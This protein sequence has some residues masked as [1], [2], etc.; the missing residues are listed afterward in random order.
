MTS[1]T[2]K[3]HCREERRKGKKIVFGNGCFDLLHVG[4]VRYLQAAKALGDILI[5]GVND[6]ASLVSL[7]KRSERDHALGGADRDPRGPGVRRLRDRLQGAHGRASPAGAEARH[8]CEGDGL[9]RGNGP[10]EGD[11]RP[12]TA[13]RSPSSGTRRTT[14]PGTSSSWCGSWRSNEPSPCPST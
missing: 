7:G 14:R 13:G 12:P 4:H 3:R 9:H 2:L 10:G 6:D 5:V 11:R 1:T 8:P